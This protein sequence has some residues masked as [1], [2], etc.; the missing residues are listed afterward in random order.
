MKIIFLDFDGVINPSMKFS[1]TGD[2][3]KICCQNLQSILKAVPDAT[4]VISSSWRTYGLAACKDILKGCGIDPK[5]VVDV[6]EGS[7]KEG[8][9]GREHHIEKWLR[10]HPEVDTFV[11]L[12]DEAEVPDLKSN[13]V[14][15][16][17]VIGL[18]SADADKAIEILSKTSKL[19]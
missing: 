2:F 19:H 18:T 4:V 14:N 7:K 5:R 6:T 12:D 1:S 16:N 15:T 3:S 11:I 9:F 17:S 13:Y 8:E 10:L